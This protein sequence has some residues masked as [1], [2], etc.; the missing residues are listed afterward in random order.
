MKGCD[1]QETK[2]WTSIYYQQSINKSVL[3]FKIQVFGCE[4]SKQLENM[5]VKHY[6]PNICL[7]VAWTILQFS[8][9]HNVHST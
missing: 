6:D 2:L 3:G 9:S 4:I 5:F 7:P 1:M 8:S